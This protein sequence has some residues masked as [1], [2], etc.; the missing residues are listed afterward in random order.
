[1][2]REA[3]DAIVE[4]GWLAATTC[5]CGTTMTANRPVAASMTD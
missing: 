4:I 3:Y 2:C 5:G 1:M